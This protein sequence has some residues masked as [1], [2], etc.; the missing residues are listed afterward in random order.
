MQCPRS[1]PEKV[2]NRD[3]PGAPRLA[4]V[5]VP[6]AAVRLDVCRYGPFGP[7]TALTAGAHFTLTDRATVAGFER[8][9][10]AL[11]EL[12]PGQLRNCP[13]DDGHALVV[14]FSDTAHA[15]TLRISLSGCAFV[16][17]GAR[18]ALASP[19]WLDA[20]E[21]MGV[22]G[23]PATMPVSARSAI[24]HDPLARRLVPIAATSVR[25]CRYAPQDAAPP[26]A[27]DEFGATADAGRVR[28]L[29]AQTEAMRLLEATER[30]PCPFSMS[31]P[32]WFVTFYDGTSSVDLLQS[33]SNCGYVTNGV[34]TGVPPAS[35]TGALDSVTTLR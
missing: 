24:A 14:R 31:A 13:E 20:A 21:N 10:N 12:P 5:M 16:S 6:L 7:A 29:L 34:L 11:A 15:V 23:C 25:V 30:V 2:T 1:L 35:W 9:V 8:A 19:A 17:N 32:S 3:T 4:S 27:R 33:A 28:A 22:A 18:T 26:G